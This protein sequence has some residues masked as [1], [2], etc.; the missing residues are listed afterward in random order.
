[1]EDAVRGGARGARGQRKTQS[2]EGRR[3][4]A[5]ALRVMLEHKILIGER[6]APD[7]HP[8][9]AVAAR[10]VAALRHEFGDDT[11]E[12]RAVVSAAPRR[13]RPAAREADEILNRPRHDAPVQSDDDT[14]RRRARDGELE[15][16]V[17][18]RLVGVLFEPPCREEPSRGSC[19]R[20][21][22]RAVR[23]ASTERRTP[24]AASMGNQRRPVRQ[25]GPS[26]LRRWRATRTRSASPPPSPRARRA[27]ARGS[28]PPAA[29]PW[30]LR[31]P[32]A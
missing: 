24:S 7:R 32:R 20:R 13:R 4:G 12:R 16:Y 29:P 30:R 22:R 5:H 3:G 9:P 15:E 1:M 28:P 14:A 21:A 25:V 10:V 8:A 19:E 2:E 17:V 27:V 26:R 31:A 18:G 6:P 23:G 11:V